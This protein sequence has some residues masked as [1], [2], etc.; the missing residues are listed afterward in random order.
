M[1]LIVKICGLSTPATLD[2]ALSAGADM[3]GF[4][5]FPASPRH[6]DLDTARLL[7]RQAKGRAIK[8]ALSVDADD[9]LIANSI[10]A[11]QPQILQ[12]HGAE[13]VARI[14]DLKQKFGLPVMKAIAVATKTDLAALPGYAAVCDRI[15]FDAKP[16]KD[17]TRPGGLGEPFDWHLLE[18]LDLKLPFMVSGGLD[19]G[20]VAEAL[21]VT[22]A[23]GVDISSGVESAPGI[24][25]P[26]MI[27]DFI[28]AAR[29]S[30]ELTAS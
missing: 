18:G 24:K 1:S 13:S 11:L 7:G 10:D 9:A 3:V 20:N 19:A 15:L 22:R 27:R 26:D 5:F 29:A 17:A 30:Q 8:V 4:V 6:V 21:R 25:D 2:A 12:L 14:R 16:P 28:R 23:G